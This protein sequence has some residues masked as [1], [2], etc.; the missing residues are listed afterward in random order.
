MKE[1]LLDLM[2]HEPACRNT[3]SQSGRNLPHSRRTQQAGLRFAS[4]DSQKVSANQP[5]LAV[6]WLATNV[7]RRTSRHIAGIRSSVR[8]TTSDRQWSVRVGRNQGRLSE[9]RPSGTGGCRITG[10]IGRIP[11]SGQPNRS[12]RSAGRTV[13]RRSDLR[14]FRAYKALKSFTQKISR[15]TPRMKS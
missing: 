1:K 3:W 2:K 9:N 15:N 8:L 10:T 7:P 13:L 12:Q 6:A 11:V 4:E 5:R 14:K